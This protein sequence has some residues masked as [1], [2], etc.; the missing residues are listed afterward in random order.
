MHSDFLPDY[1]QS[2]CVT[3]IPLYINLFVVQMA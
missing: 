3:T 2:Q 1:G